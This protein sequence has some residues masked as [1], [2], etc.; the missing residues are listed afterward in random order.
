MNR[1]QPAPLAYV[2][3]IR[4]KGCGAAKTFVQPMIANQK[5]GIMTWNG[6]QK[7][8]E[9]AI[10]IALEKAPRSPCRLSLNEAFDHGFA[11]APAINVIAKEDDLCVVAAVGMDQREGLFKHFE[12]AVDVANGVN[13]M[14]HRQG[15]NEKGRPEKSGLCKV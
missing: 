13:W 4:G 14:S 6:L 11:I 8:F 5:V 15:L 2:N 1:E 10:V 7:P 3:A 12:L 9:H